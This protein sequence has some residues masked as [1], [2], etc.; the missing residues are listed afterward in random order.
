MLALATVGTIV[1]VATFG[2]NAFSTE[3]YQRAVTI[4]GTLAGPI[5]GFYFGSRHPE[6]RHNASAD[7]S[8]AEAVPPARWATQSRSQT[9]D[10]VTVTDALQL[11]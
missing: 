8:S 5:L 9:D 10:A 1:V 3:D 6:S 2:V 7:R 4:L 11:T